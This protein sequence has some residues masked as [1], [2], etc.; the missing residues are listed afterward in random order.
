MQTLGEESVKWE[1][2]TSGPEGVGDSD[3]ADVGIKA[4]SAV[5]VES[6]INGDI[7]LPEGC[8]GLSAITK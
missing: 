1:V 2:H 3:S 5:L 6:V 4:A 7:A 8:P